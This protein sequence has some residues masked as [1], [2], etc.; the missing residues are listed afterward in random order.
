MTGISGRI[1]ITG[2]GGTLGHAIAY[3][4][5]TQRWDC[6][7]T[8]YSRSEL[9][10]AQMRAQYPKLRYVLGDVADYDRLSAA[11]AGHD[12]VIHAA[13]MKRIP[14]CEQHPT[15]CIRVNV[16]GSANVVRACVAHGVG[17]CLGVSTDKAVRASTPYGAS[18]LLLEAL[19][20]AQPSEPTRFVCVRYGN[21]VASNGS[22]IP[23]WRGQHAFGEPLTLTD[24]AMTRFWMAPSDAVAL[25]VAAQYEASGVV[26][27]PKMGALSLVEMAHYLHPGADLK[28]IGF[29]SDEKLHEDLVHPNELAMESPH[30][31]HIGAGTR[32]HCYTS[33][34]APRLSKEAFLAMVEEAERYA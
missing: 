30:H 20:R 5:E 15:E 10:Q 25:L 13:A 32:G 14:E 33:D 9:R 31:Y 11:I 21:V 8:I 3:A 16:L 22:V 7:L 1:L 28:V 24:R 19:W 34:A 12:V 4:A 18:K 26:L 29:R 2:G 27:V 6:S 23:L 17:L